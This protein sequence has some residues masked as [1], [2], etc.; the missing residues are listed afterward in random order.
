MG[1]RGVIAP[2]WKPP[3][4]KP[5]VIVA[6][7]PA[8]APDPMIEQLKQQLKVSQNTT[9]GG[10]NSQATARSA[11]L[12]S[13]V[14]VP[15][16]DLSGI[17]SQS[18]EL[19]ALMSKMMKGQGFDNIDIAGDPAARA[20]SVSR[21]RAAENSRAAEAERLAASG[22]TGSGEFDSSLAQIREL[23]NEDIASNEADIVNRRR[24]E[25]MSTALAGAGLKLSDLDRQSRDKRAAYDAE[26]EK[27]RIRR[28]GLE[29]AAHLDSS[30]EGQ[31][32]SIQSRLLD[33]LM[34]E[35]SR[36]DTLRER[37]DELRR[38]AES[39]RLKQEL[40]KQ[41]VEAGRRRTYGRGF[42]LPSR[43]Y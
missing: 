39:E 33:Q 20:Y 8:P 6:P 40:L 37:T 14:N 5:P 36:Q 29:S 12:A 21:R 11:D 34:A 15:A 41:Q 43:A 1:V 25:A 17:E 22:V 38:N 28:S 13:P 26:I 4:P 27:E 35:Q 30:R 7:T 2:G 42:V 31:D 10:A 18:A 24:G 32:F 23:S 9:G 19:K 3:A 16:L